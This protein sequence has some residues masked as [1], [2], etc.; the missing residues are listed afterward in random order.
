M[1]CIKCGENM[2]EKLG[3]VHDCNCCG[4]YIP[5]PKPNGYYAPKQI[6]DEHDLDWIDVKSPVIIRKIIETED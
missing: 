3:G 6:R 5:G 2:I 1:K 4:Y